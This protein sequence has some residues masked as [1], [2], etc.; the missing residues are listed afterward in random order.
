MVLL[1]TGVAG[2]IGTNF[3]YYYLNKYKDQ[4]IIGLDKLTYAGD[5]QNFNRL[6]P[7]QKRRFEFIQGDIA[8]KKHIGIIFKK[9]D[10]TGII[11]FAAESHVDRS[12]QGA[13]VFIKSNVLGVFNLIENAR[14]N[15]WI[16]NEWHENFRFIQISTD[17]VYGSI[18]G[19]SRFTEQSPLHPNNPYSASKAAGDLFIHSYCNTYSFPGIVSRCSNNYGPFQ[20]PEKLI[21]LVIQKALHHRDIPLYGDGKQ[22]RDWLYVEDHCSAIDTIFEKG[23][24]CN[25]YNV[26]GNNEWNNIDLVQCIISILRD[27]TKDKKINNDLICHVPDRLGHDRRYAIDP[28]KIKTQLHWQP[29][30][31]FKEGLRST[32]EWYIHNKDWIK[33]RNAIQKS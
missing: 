19:D 20:H 16:R 4:K 22:I 23:T 11:N 18:H 32:I 17:E 2:F 21:P 5:V 24:T 29:E 9:Y 14:K 8:D 3:V 28:T 7:D 15:L 12:I 1:V 10:V 27:M 26:G 30:T 13:E 33:T 6:E 31:Q 25:I